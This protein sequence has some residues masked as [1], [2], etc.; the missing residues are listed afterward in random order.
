MIVLF[1]IISRSVGGARVVGDT[2]GSQSAKF[3]GASSSV[4]R[5]KS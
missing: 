5:E 1:S 2:A 4:H 3:A